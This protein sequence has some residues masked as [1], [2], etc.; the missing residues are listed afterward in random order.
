MPEARLV[1]DT[2]FNNSPIYWTGSPEKAYNGYAYVLCMS[3]IGGYIKR[4]S[5]LNGVRPVVSVSSNVK[6]TGGEGSTT[7]PFIFE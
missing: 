2:V 4:S 7:N 5:D 6:I 1:T 3:N